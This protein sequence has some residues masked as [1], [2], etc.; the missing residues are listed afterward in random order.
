M[1]V[2]VSEHVRVREREREYIHTLSK[3]FKLSHI[4]IELLDMCINL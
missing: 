3:F 1:H 4:L 2:R